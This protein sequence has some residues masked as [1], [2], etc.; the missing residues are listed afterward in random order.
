M[1]LNKKNAEFFIPDN[2][3]LD[4]AFL[5]TT[6]MAIGAHQD[7]LEIMAYQGIEECFQSQEK[8]FFGIVVTDGGGSAR[9]DIYKNYT[10]EEMIN[11]RKIEQKKAAYLG[12]FG[13]LALLDY[14]SKEVKDKDNKEVV[15]E[16]KNLIL[17]SQPR[18]I[19]THNLADKHDTH[20]GVVTKVIK[21]I[22]ALP[23]NKRP[24]KIYGC[25]VWRNLDWLND[26]E[27]IYLDV[28]KHPNLASALVEVF[29]SQIIGGKR[30][31][32]ATIGRR[33]ANATYNASH[34]T[35]QQE[36]LTYAMDL[37]PLIINDELSVKD[38]VSD[39]IDRFKAD[40]QNKIDRM[41]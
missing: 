9:D 22:R 29:D 28:S 16:L 4:K 41:L 13:L 35:D 32:L 2:I 14:P 5:R 33:L 30:Y 17:K 31:D 26:D 6:H 10:N 34:Q 38:F 15:E 20:I 27:K 39:A 19:Y 37:T 12:E 18:I 40:V 8:Y 36:A 7:D 3:E 24:E 23:K 11:V 25:E 21:A 1:N